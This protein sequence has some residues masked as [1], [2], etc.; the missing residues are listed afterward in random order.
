M[1]EEKI[2]I[3]YA[4]PA[5]KGRPR[6]MKNGH[7][8]TPEKTRIYEA[9]V[10]ESYETQVGHPEPFTGPVRVEIIAG[11]SIPKSWSKK[12]RE[13]A[14]NRRI[15]VTKKPDAD[16]IAK[17]I[18][19]SLNGLAYIDDSQIAELFVSKVYSPTFPQTLVFIREIYEGE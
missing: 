12:K 9:I 8:Y 5:G 13:Q 19:D 17:A 11:Y 3:I 4:E 1:A 16:N 10:R 18:C 15:P 6:H 2:F 7:T 14:M